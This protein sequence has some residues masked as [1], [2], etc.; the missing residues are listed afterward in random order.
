MA[1]L[2]ADLDHS[3]EARDE[4]TLKVKTLEQDN[5]AKEQEITSLTH[6]KA[7]LEKDV[8]TLEEQ[9]KEHKDKAS[10]HSTHTAEIEALT[11]KTHLHEEE[12]EQTERQLKETYEK[13]DPWSCT[14]RI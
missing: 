12:A 5:L 8:T 2:Q 9:V 6:Q 3:N 7:V 13:C 14:V 10:Q 4:L 1:Q 11:R